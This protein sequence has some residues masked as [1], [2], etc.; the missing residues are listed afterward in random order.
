MLKKLLNTLGAE[1]L[2]VSVMT[3]AH[4]GGSTHAQ[5]D[6]VDV[7]VAAGS[8]EILK[9]QADKHTSARYLCR[10]M[11]LAP[12]NSVIAWSIAATRVSALARLK[13]KGGRIL[14]TLP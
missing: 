9:T 6:I 11:G 13:T 1:L 10:Y 4:A 14:N 3:G 7:A 5:G 2:G 12:S 8:F